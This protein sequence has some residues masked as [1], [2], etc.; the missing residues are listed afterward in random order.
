MPDPILK[1]AMKEIEAVL[2]KY[3]CAGM[4]TLASEKHVE[5]LYEISPSWS[6]AWLQTMPDG[7]V[8]VRVRSKLKDYPNKEVQ[9][10]IISLTAGMF[11]AFAN[12]AGKQ[13]AQMGELMRILS[14]HLGEITHW[15]K[16][17]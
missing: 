13:Q 9:G 12:M 15:E 10:K 11:L 17:E 4:V 14:P 7:G 2:K 16:D 8:A 6:C 1:T 3:D 5:F